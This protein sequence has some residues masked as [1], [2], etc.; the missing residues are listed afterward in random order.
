MSNSDLKP[1]HEEIAKRA[2]AIFEESGRIPGRDEQN[3]LQAESQLIA[4]RKRE[5]EARSS[6]SSKPSGKAPPRQN[7]GHQ[8]GQ[9]QSGH[10]HSLSHRS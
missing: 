10:A 1:T 9:R 7:D 5:S 3:W 4:A 2:Q 6:A 8:T